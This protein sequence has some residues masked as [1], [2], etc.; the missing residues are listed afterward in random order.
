MSDDRSIS[1]L[2]RIRNFI[3]DQDLI[4]FR[5]NSSEKLHTIAFNKMMN[6]GKGFNYQGDVF[7]W[8][9]L[10]PALDIPQGKWQKPVRFS[11]ADGQEEEPQEG[12]YYYFDVRVSNIQRNEGE[13]D[14]IPDNATYILFT[15][16]IDSLEISDLRGSVSIS[17]ENYTKYEDYGW[18]KFSDSRRNF[19][20]ENMQYPVQR[21]IPLDQDNWMDF[22][23]SSVDHRNMNRNNHASFRC[24]IAKKNNQHLSI[25]AWS[26]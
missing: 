23:P 20:F 10:T 18:T 21:I 13:K 9:Q 14:L 12:D 5:Q 24:P 26:Y 22:I 11:G 4:L 1:E 3:P 8:K 25:Y 2:P 15:C 16:S 7:D 17:P 6:E 19:V